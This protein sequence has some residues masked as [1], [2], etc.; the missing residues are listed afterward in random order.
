MILADLFEKQVCKYDADKSELKKK[1]PD[2]SGLVKKQTIMLK[3][4]KKKAK[5][6]VLVVWL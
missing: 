3:L 5:Y 4:M 1:I 6:L 2:T